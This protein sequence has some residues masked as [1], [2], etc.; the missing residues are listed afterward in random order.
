MSDL[1]LMS[2]AVFATQTTRLGD[3]LLLT[4]AMLGVMALIYW[5]MWRGWHRSEGQSPASLAVAPAGWTPRLVGS[6]IYASTTHRGQWMRRVGWFDL[7]A[8]SRAEVAVGPEGVR[9]ARDGSEPFFIARDR[10]ESIHL[11]PGIAGKIV[12]GKG[13][14]II[15]WRPGTLPVDTGILPDAEIRSAMVSAAMEFI[16]E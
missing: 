15:S 12:G 8:R 4:V 14:L 2:E 9:I 16:D 5:G 7:G 1:L 11:A 6:A 13:V 3:R 10:I